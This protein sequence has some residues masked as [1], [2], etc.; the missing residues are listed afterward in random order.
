MATTHPELAKEMHPSLNGKLNPYNV[1]ASTTRKVWWVCKNDPEHI[2]KSRGADRVD[3]HGCPYCMLTPQSKEELIILFELK[4][5]FQSINPKGYK[6]RTGKKLFS[7]DIYIPE[8]NMII[9]YDGHHWH[10]GKRKTDLKKTESLSKAG[11]RILRIREYPLK[12][13][14]NDDIIF[15]RPFEIK[16]VIDEI[17]NYI[18][19]RTNVEQHIASK[20]LEYLNQQDLHNQKAMERY[21]DKI[22]KEKA[23]SG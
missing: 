3:G 4:R 15:K 16:T 13:L 1:M 21:I 7:V 19:L 22:L 14:T 12:M 9:E 11:Y 8:V 17:L 18:L 2:W 6:V 10:K 5:I 20:V 23:E